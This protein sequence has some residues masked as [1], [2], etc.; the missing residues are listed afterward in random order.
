MWS[1]L[2]SSREHKH[3]Q[4]DALYGHCGLLGGIVRQVELLKEVNVLLFYNDT[5]QTRLSKKDLVKLLLRQM[6]YFFLQFHTETHRIY[7]WHAENSKSMFLFQT[8]YHSDCKAAASILK[9]KTW[10]N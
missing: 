5:G 8:V 1:D 6:K 9:Q 2:T 10:C 4:Y 7:L 3:L